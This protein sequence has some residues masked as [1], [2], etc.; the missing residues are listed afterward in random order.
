MFL[1]DNLGL[2][3]VEEPDLEAIR[4]L[5]ND[6]STWVHLTDP[7]LITCDA[8]RRWFDGLAGRP[9]RIYFTVFD[10]THPFIGIVR[11]DEYDPTN[12]SI[13][14]GADVVPLL[15]NRGYGRKIFS[16]IKKYCFDI[17]NLHR[18]WLAVLENNGHALRLYQK[19]GF[20][21][22]GRYRGAIF[23][24]GR[25]L[26]YVLMSLLEKEYRHDSTI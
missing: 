14:V 5:R 6:P 10:E 13:R 21:V 22:E 18:I 12:R 9:D 4:S 1:H 11:M 7:H 16:A 8:Q 17:L 26:D 25:Y 24:D 23:R 15:R 3:V 19:Q 20:Q 2:R